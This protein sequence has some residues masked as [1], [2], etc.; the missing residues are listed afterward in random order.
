[1]NKKEL[2]S[3]YKQ[4]IQPMGI[5]QIKNLSNGKIFIGSSKDLPGI[6]NRNKFQLKNGLHRNKTMQSDF[7]EVGADNFTFE[8]L[9]QLQ[10]KEDKKVDYTEELHMLEEMWL[11]K[12]QP[13]NENGYN[14]RSC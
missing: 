11:E 12:M 7:I 4:T 8:I 9:D 10:P 2:S 13:Y 1:M 14:P 3:E 5:Y 6:I